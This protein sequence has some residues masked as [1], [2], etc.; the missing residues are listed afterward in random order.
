MYYNRESE[1]PNIDF[2]IN[3]ISIAIVVHHRKMKFFNCYPQKMIYHMNSIR[4]QIINWGGSFGSSYREYYTSVR[5]KLIKMCIKPLRFHTSF[6]TIVTLV[7]LLKQWYKFILHQRY[8]IGGVGY[9]EAK[10]D[11]E[12]MRG[13]FTLL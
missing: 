4:N 5:Q 13:L 8:S 9:K 12:K 7:L 11:F 10:E 2:V 6:K 1:K 3:D